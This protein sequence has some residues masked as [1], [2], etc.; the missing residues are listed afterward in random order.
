MRTNH[1]V[2]G[3]Y[4]SFVPMVVL[5]WAH[6]LLCPGSGES[7]IPPLMIL[8][9]ANMMMIMKVLVIIDDDDNDYDD[10]DNRP[11]CPKSGESVIPASEFKNPGFLSQQNRKS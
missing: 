11:L 3:P 1:L 6:P 8:V 4:Q 10:N 2:A 9:M 7:V 5:L